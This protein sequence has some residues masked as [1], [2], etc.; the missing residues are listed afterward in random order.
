MGTFGPILPA[1]RCPASAHL[2]RAIVAASLSVGALAA[3][4]ATAGDKPPIPDKP[5][6]GAGNAKPGGSAA[7]GTS[8]DARR[9]AM[10][11][12][13]GQ[14]SASAN[15]AGSASA[16][17]GD[18][19]KK[20]ASAWAAINGINLKN[21]KLEDRLEA[22]R[23]KIDTRKKT[24]DER[25]QAE[26]ERIR[27]RWGALTDRPNVQDE[28]RLHALRIA[29]LT[30]IQELAEVEGKTAV[31]GRALKAIDRENARHDKRMQ[32]IALTPA[33]TPGGGQ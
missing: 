31:E 1:L 18:K 7:A 11:A 24:F 22:L 14:A 10:H 30:R 27:I 29:R 4:T 3:S 5:P 6:S 15:P 2:R 25:R 23:Q 13:T 26:Q 20:A 9:A 28:L 12:A 33:A 32:E 16:A 17:P 21:G 19:Q 8:Q